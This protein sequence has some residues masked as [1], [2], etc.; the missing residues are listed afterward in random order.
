MIFAKHIEKQIVS[1]V[2]NDSQLAELQNYMLNF[3]RYDCPNSLYQAWKILILGTTE[4][5]NNQD[6][7]LKGAW[8]RYEEEKGDCHERI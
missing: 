1:N 8:E 7:I 2:L 3:D 6:I 5:K 4:Y